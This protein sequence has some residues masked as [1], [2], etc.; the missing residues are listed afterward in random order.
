MASIAKDKNGLKRVQFFNPAGER[1]T[2]RM[3]QAS[4]HD[5]RTIAT[6][7][8]FLVNA[9]SNGTAPEPSV[10][11]WLTTIGD[12]LYGK[13]VKHGLAAPRLKQQITTLKAFLD[14]YIAKRT[15][16]KG[17][18]STV[19][20]HTR[21]CLIEFFGA[22]RP[23]QH[24]TIAETKNWR[25]WLAQPKNETEQ[26][27]QGLSDNTVRRLCGIA[28][29]FFNDALEAR[30]ITEN[31]FARMKGVSVRANKSRYRFVSRE[32]A[33]KVIAACPDSQW[34]LLFALSRY[35]GLRCPSEHLLL[36]WGDIDW[37]A[38][39]ITVRSPKTEHHEG[40][41]ERVMPLFP[42][43]LPYLEAVREELLTSDFDPKQTPMSGLPIITRYLKRNC[44]LRTQLSR[45]S[46]GQ[47]TS[48]GRNSFRISAAR[49]RP[50]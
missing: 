6:N 4:M 31:P 47:G 49:G 41:A 34:K 27:G 35:G 42:E 2:I 15:D 30:L 28:R 44:N 8:Q 5:A 29:Q 12:D 14:S 21:R 13:L 1:K 32:V 38:G 46:H 3:G 45:S 18:T 40:K 39:R 26:G 50:N 36:R 10:F 25:R 43:L 9:K 22:D 11:S 23:L 37:T 19:Y 24:I 20:N 16:V 17:S 7:I 48:L 33:D